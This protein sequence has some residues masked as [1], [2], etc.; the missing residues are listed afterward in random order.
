MTYRI[1]SPVVDP[2]Y[3][4]LEFALAAAYEQAADSAGQR[5]RREER[6]WREQQ[7]EAE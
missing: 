1:K 5:P 4:S 3:E 7:K 6:I 2:N